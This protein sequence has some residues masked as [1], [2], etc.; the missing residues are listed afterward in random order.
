MKNVN[1]KNL[2]NVLTEKELSILKKLDKKQNGS[3]LKL[4]YLTDCNDKVSAQYKGKYN[5]SKITTISVRK[6]IKYENLK[7]VI[8]ERSNPNYVPSIRKAWYH[9]IDSMLC[10]HN[11]KE[12]YYVCLFPNKFGKANTIYL[13]NGI[14]IPKENLKRREV[15]QP[16]FWTQKESKPKMITLGLDKIIEVY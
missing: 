2:K 14:R 9:H 11:T 13:L 10:K 5:V 15:M 3:Y 1:R 8:E 12:Q 7:D 16:S 6:G 4:Q